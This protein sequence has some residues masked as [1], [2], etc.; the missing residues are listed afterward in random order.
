[1]VHANAMK[2]IISKLLGR[3]GDLVDVQPV[4]AL[5]LWGALLAVLLLTTFRGSPWA[6]PPNSNPVWFLYNQFRRFL[7]GLTLAG[8]LVGAMSLSR[9][10]L[11]QTLAAFQRSHGR[12]TE[13][14][15]NAVQTIWGAEQQQGELNV[16]LYYEEETTERIESEDLTKPAVL[17]KKIVRHDIAA[18]P[19]IAARHDVT[20]RQ[21]P[22]RKGSALYGGYETTCRFQWRLR[23]PTE[24]EL[25]C[26]LK[27][28]L[29]AAT[30][31][32]DELTAT[33][34][35]RDV[36]AQMQ[37]KEGALLLARPLKATEELALTISFKS[38]GMSF[39]YLQVKEP[40]EI[41]DFL[42]T[43]TLPDLPK[44]R[45]NYPEGCMTPTSIKSTSDNLGSILTFR[46]DHALSSKGMGIALPTLPQPGATTN[47]VLA[48]IERGWL[49]LFAMLIL[50]LILAEV[51]QAVLASVLF[52]AAIACAYG[53]LADFSDLLFGFWGTAVLIMIPMFVV[54][55]WLLTRV[56]PARSGQ[57][58]AVQ[59]LLFGIV[60]PMVAGLDSE[61]QRLY[62]N[63][64][65]LIFLAFAAWQ[66]LMLDAGRNDSRA[67]E[68]QTAKNKATVRPESAPLPEPSP[69]G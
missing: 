60:Y 45:L 44:A 39:W 51:K 40:R 37:V 21:N 18:N 14:N 32:Y 8:F 29:P 36:L 42:L 26:V 67:A 53:L 59:L 2:T 3:A 27:F 4:L 11:H 9:A 16:Q 46:L 6:V 23:N 61:R 64:C 20:L 31:M 69:I 41:R 1:M 50:G 15:Y 30:A 7:W 68:E 58:M 63:V 62:L 12:I 10:Y 65:A 5:F 34:N 33:L 19:F 54:L 57:L 48:E 43:L 49:L 55:A 13:A 24:R 17:R 25:D 38:R 28:P 52:G 56:V 22:R 35:G 47:A 66:L